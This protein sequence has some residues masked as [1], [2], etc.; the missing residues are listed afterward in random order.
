MENIPGKITIVMNIL[1]FY[2]LNSDFILWLVDKHDI[3]F[4]E[5]FTSHQPPYESGFLDGRM[6]SHLENKGLER[7]GYRLRS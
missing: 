3:L 2:E 1:I 5:L 7:G 4:C 6:F